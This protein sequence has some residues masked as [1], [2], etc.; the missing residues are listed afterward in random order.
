MCCTLLLIIC[1]IIFPP[2]PVL[3]VKGL[4]SSDFLLNVL[5]TLLG[6]IPGL[7]HSL[8]IIFERQ[9]SRNMDRWYYQQ[10]WT[11]RERLSQSRGSPATNNTGNNTSNSNT[12][13]P[14]PCEHHHYYQQQQPQPSQQPNE[15]SNLISKGSPPPYTV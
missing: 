11:A 7:V 9:Q 4:C 13:P 14:Q 8:I 2:F 12:N 6:Y 10:G 15:E 5:L 3:L 1:A